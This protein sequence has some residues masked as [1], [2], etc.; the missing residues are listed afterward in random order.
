MHDPIW[1]IVL[2][3]RKNLKARSGFYLWISFV[4]KSTMKE[5]N[6]HNWLLYYVYKLDES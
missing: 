5:V 3:W 1:F 6:I 2:E 4:C